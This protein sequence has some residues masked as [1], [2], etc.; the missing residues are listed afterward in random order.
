VRCASTCDV[1]PI[2]ESW[3][4]APTAEVLSLLHR[5]CARWSVDLGWDLARDWAAVDPARRVGLL[6]G[7]VVRG[8]D[9]QARGWA[10]GVDLDGERQVGAVV[11]DD[12]DA[13]QHL[14]DALTADPSVAHT[15]AFVRATDVVNAALLRA[16][17][18]DVQPYAYLIAPTAG[19]SLGVDTWRTDD[20]VATAEVLMRAYADDRSLRPF[21]RRGTPDDWLD[22]V[23]AL[24]MR[25]GCGVFSPHCSVVIRDGQRL[26]GVA[27]VTSIGPTTAHLAQLAVAPDARGRGL[28]QTLLAE[29]RA[30][31]GRVLRASR[32][33]L[34][35]S[36]A[37]TPA[38]TLYARAG[39]RH[40]GDFVAAV[41][42]PCD[43][44]APRRRPAATTRADTP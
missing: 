19:A 43:P 37:N 35:V 10:F 18:F 2:C 32:L 40:T 28:A 8:T 38:L 15:L 33:S 13:A 12:A 11:A 26:L 41:F 5:E 23:D 14:I 34:L 29:A 20:R 31:A 9:H 17:G 6:P 16:N 44:S 24:T 27:L 36:T 22:Y 1:P 3:Q 42:T 25:P 39:F 30:H 7:W 4:A 21:A